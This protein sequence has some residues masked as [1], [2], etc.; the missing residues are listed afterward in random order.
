MPFSIIRSDITKVR[1]DA[2]VNTANP[3]PC[4]GSGTDS[5]VYRAAGEARLLAERKKI[6]DIAPGDAASTPAFALQAKYII[7]TVGPVWEGGS[8]G[9]REI[10]RACYA[11]SLALAAELGCASIA[12][13]LIATGVYGFPKDEALSIALSE[14]GRFLL[15]HE[16]RVTLVVL[17][18]KAFELSEQQVGRIEQYIDEHGASLLHQA[19]YGGGRDTRRRRTAQPE[20][21][22]EA[23]HIGTTVF[24]EKPETAVFSDEVLPPGVPDV[25]GKS[26]DEVLDSPGEPFQR[27]L[28]RLIDASGMDDVTVY[29]KANIDRK[30]F[31]RIR[32]KSDYMPKK[33][34]AVAFAV[35]LELDLLSRAGFTLSPSSLFD[36]IVAYY[37]TNR[38]Y[39]ILEI[40][41]ALFRYGQP[42]LGE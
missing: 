39:D 35:A 40:N 34:T 27:R 1:A 29:K 7:H 24:S 18:R 32:C 36:L 25:A 23:Q 8:R 33:K 42:I 28:F 21:V 10:L 31:S 15:T 9:E 38:I 11:H 13:P 22:D 30:V 20:E 37:I 16:M 26:L 17:D 6:G 4:V 41:A 5:A 2:I 12:F 3:R 19:E 14:I